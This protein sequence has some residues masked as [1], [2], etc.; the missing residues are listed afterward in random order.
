[1]EAFIGIYQEKEQVDRYLD[2]IGM[3]PEAVVEVGPFVSQFQAVAWLEFMAAKIPGCNSASCGGETS[4]QHLWY[5]F[6][7]AG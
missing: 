6:T 7:A 5:G 2:S 4:G 3:E 1:M